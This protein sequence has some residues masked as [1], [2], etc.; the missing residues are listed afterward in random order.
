[1]VLGGVVLVGVVLGG[2]GLEGVVLGV[3][4]EVVV[5]GGV[6]VAAVGGVELDGVEFVV[7]SAGGGADD[8]GGVVVGG[9]GAASTVRSA[10]DGDADGDAFSVEGTA[11]CDAMLPGAATDAGGATG[12]ECAAADKEAYCSSKPGATTPIEGICSGPAADVDVDVLLLAGAVS[13]ATV[14]PAPPASGR[15]TTGRMPLAKAAAASRPQLV[16]ITGI[17]RP[18]RLRELCP[19]TEPPPSLLIALILNRPEWRV[20]GNRHGSRAEVPVSG[21]RTKSVAPAG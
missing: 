11:S 5:V 16:P 13:S 20:H 3:G 7:G 14:S 6:V 2:V 12:L 1:V 9:S 19:P 15:A 18:D 10:G 17:I 21:S 4:L 8:G